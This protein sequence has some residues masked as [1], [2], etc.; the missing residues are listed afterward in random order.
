[1]WPTI[2]PLPGTSP[3]DEK[4]EVLLNGCPEDY[5]QFKFDI[6]VNEP[7]PDAPSVYDQKNAQVVASYGERAGTLLYGFVFDEV[8]MTKIETVE[9]FRCRGCARQMY[10][11]LVA[12]YPDRPVR[13]AGNSNE[14][15][16]DF[17]LSRCRAEGILGDA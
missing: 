11:A 15:V 4:V 14:P 7:D 6:V 5:S 2:K 13:D 16:G 17:V 10:E 9:K 12:H 3:M 8:W 1:M